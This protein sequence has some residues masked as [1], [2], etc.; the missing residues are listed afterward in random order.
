MLSVADEYISNLNP[1]AR[2]ILFGQEFSD[3]SYAIAKTD[4]IIK[5]QHAEN[6]ILGDTLKNDGHWDRT[7]DYGLANPPFGVEWKKQQEAV[8]SVA[9]DLDT[10]STSEFFPSHSPFLARSSPSLALQTQQLS[11]RSQDKPALAQ[12][13]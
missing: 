9:K 2:L 4:L 11:L 10:L 8:T 6:L 1:D 12:A 13:S 5:G 3:E 7:F